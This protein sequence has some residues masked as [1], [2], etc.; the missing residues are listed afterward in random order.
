MLVAA[1]LQTANLGRLTDRPPAAAVRDATQLLVVL[2]DERSR[3]AGDV[4]DGRCGHPI[5]VPEPAEAAA[6]EDPVDR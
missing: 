3:M 5:G 4:A 2:V 1:T 6:P